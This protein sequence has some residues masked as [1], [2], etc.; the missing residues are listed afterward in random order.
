MGAPQ[1]EAEPVDGRLLNITVTIWA[2]GNVFY[3]D[4]HT[5]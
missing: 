4:Y 1:E 5:A 3:K 2:C